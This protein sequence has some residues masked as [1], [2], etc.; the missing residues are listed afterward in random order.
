MPAGE[1]ET[2][3][4]V[5]VVEDPGVSIRTEQWFAAVGLVRMR[6]R[7]VFTQPLTNELGELVGEF[8]DGETA[9]MELQRF[10]LAGM[11]TEEP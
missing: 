3:R 7:Q 2:F 1:F 6:D 9:E 11:S 4:V 5:R 10:S 8:T